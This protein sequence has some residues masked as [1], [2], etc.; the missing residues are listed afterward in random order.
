[1]LAITPVSFSLAHGRQRTMSYGWPRPCRIPDWHRLT[2]LFQP[3]SPCR[4][5]IRPCLPLLAMSEHDGVLGTLDFR[6]H[7]HADM[8]CIHRSTPTLLRL[9]HILSSIKEADSVTYFDS[10]LPKAIQIAY[11]SFTTDTIA[12]LGKQ[13]AGLLQPF[14]HNS[15]YTTIKHIDKA[16]S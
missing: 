5:T 9:S 6:S 15:P 10:S 1:M 12:F 2:A 4:Y 13:R 16:P 7:R 3:D 14:V 11:T 8:L